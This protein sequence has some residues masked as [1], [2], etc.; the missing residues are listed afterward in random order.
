MIDLKTFSF[1]T[2]RKHLVFFLIC[3]IHFNYQALQAFITI[4]FYGKLRKYST[5]TKRKVFISLQIGIC[6]VCHRSSVRVKHSICLLSTGG[7]LGQ[8]ALVLIFFFVDVGGDGD[9]V[10]GGNCGVSINSTLT[11]SIL[12]YSHLVKLNQTIWWRCSEA[13]LLEPQ[14]ATWFTQTKSESFFIILVCCTIKFGD[15]V[16]Q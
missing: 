7:S 5:T 14:H 3:W 6:I 15:Y 9:G 4:N 8:F 16:T 10:G 13:Y 12:A 11:H 2:H 1:N